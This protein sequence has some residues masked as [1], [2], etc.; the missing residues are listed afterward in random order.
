MEDNAQNNGGKARV[1]KAKK[2]QRSLMSVDKRQKK[3][4]FLDKYF[5]F[6]VFSLG[7]ALNRDT[8]QW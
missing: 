5:I 3:S 7:N 4:K 1:E 8:S 2:R 6:H